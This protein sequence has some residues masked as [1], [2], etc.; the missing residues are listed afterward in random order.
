MAIK[1]IL[2]GENIENYNEEFARIKKDI[3]LKKQELLEL[4]SDTQTELNTAIDNLS[5][6]VNIRITELDDKI[7]DKVDTLEAKKVDRKALSDL[8]IKLGNKLN[9]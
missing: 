5:T 9:D 8:F 2:F 3:L 7:Q 1:D 4:I 6:D